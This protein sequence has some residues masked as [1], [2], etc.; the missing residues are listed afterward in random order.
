M[1]SGM[2]PIALLFL[3]PLLADAQETKTYQGISPPGVLTLRFVDTGLILEARFEDS[4]GNSALD[5]EETARIILTVTNQGPGKAYQVE[6]E[7][8]LKGTTRHVT[9]HRLDRNLGTLEPGQSA[10]AEVALK[11]DEEIESGKVTLRFEAKDRYERVAPPLEVTIDTRALTP[12]LLKV[13]DVGIDDDDQG[14]SYGNANGKI[15]KGETIEVKAIIQN[16]GQG[17]AGQVTVELVPAEGVFF[18][19]KQSFNLGD[20]GPGQYREIEFAFTVP[21]SYAGNE[22][23]PFRFATTCP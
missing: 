21:P 4:N 9:S 13:A 5:A 2:W 6:V 7:G 8:G 18:M 22:E 1:R 11:A 10:T 14:N 20:L 19:G 12:P 23:L 17:E 16:Q 15:E 3:F